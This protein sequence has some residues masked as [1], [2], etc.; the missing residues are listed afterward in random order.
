VLTAANA[1]D[2]FGPS[3]AIGKAKTHSIRMFLRMHA[4]KRHFSRLLQEQANPD[5]LL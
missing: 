3:S 1:R 5:Y 2:F 4:L